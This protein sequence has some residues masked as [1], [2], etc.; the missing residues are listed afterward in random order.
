V[1]ISKSTT[2]DKTSDDGG[3]KWTRPA[4]HSVTRKSKPAELPSSAESLLLLYNNDGGAQLHAAGSRRRTTLWYHQ[5]TQ[6]RTQLTFNNTYIHTHTHTTSQQQH[7]PAATWSQDATGT[8][9]WLDAIYRANQRNWI[10]CNWL[11]KVNWGP[12]LY[13]G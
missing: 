3:G 4:L 7:R 2:N 6:K 11:M 13:N 12:S 8:N 5:C 10:H 9:V 1:T